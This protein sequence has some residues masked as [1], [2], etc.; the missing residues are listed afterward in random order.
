MSTQNQAGRTQRILEGSP[1]L[2]LSEQ[3]GEAECSTPQVVP[4]RSLRPFGAF[5]V[6]LESCLF[7]LVSR[8][9]FGKSLY[10][11]LLNV[12]LHRHCAGCQIFYTNSPAALIPLL[13]Q[14][15]TTYS[16]VRRTFPPKGSPVQPYCS[17]MTFSWPLTLRTSTSIVL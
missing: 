12:V 11:S 4:T 7:S 3:A 14:H 6:F 8:Q 1:E 17:L 15:I 9:L 10:K 2:S 16:S 13:R 5:G